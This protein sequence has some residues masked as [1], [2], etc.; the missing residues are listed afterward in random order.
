[1]SDLHNRPGDP[2]S[3]RL[4]VRFEGGDERRGAPL[5]AI[6][7]GEVDI[8]TASVMQ[9][10]IK[11]AR[12]AGGASNLVLDLAEV[13]FMDS[14]GLRVIVQLHQQLAAEHGALVLVGARGD[15]QN[16]LALTGL[17]RHLAIASTLEE[18]NELL[19]GH[20]GRDRDDVA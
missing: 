18:A 12:D 20:A 4:A 15:V 5:R 11:E 14:S 3:L 17:D 16:V 10:Q 19:A 7:S 9:D 13:Q 6:V 1:V 2:D 8:A